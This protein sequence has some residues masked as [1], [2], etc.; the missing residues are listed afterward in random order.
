MRTEVNVRLETAAS[1]LLTASLALAAAGLKLTAMLCGLAYAAL[2]LWLLLRTRS[3]RARLLCGW[4][5]PL[6]MIVARGNELVIVYLG[7]AF[8]VVA[9]QE[10]LWRDRLSSL[11]T[12]AFPALLLLGIRAYLDWLN[13]KP[14]WVRL[15]R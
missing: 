9:L 8:T 1:L 5:L 13:Y 3:A 15:A 2:A 7:A 12:L 14:F 4:A 6:L 10:S 11:L